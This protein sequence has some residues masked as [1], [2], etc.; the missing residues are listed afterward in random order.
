[1]DFVSLLAL[2]SLLTILAT[3]CLALLSG[4]GDEKRRMLAYA[5]PFPAA[6][7]KCMSRSPDVFSAL[8]R[9]G[10]RADAGPNLF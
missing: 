10:V 2:L 6:G 5:T 7:R 4:H 1:M 9:R 3:S 8:D